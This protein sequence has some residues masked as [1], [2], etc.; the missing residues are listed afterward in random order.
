MF[1]AA[2][3]V[4]GPLAASRSAGNRAAHRL[5]PWRAKRCRGKPSRVLYLVVIYNE[6]NLPR[7]LLGAS[8][9][10]CP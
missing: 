6:S 9:P 4:L 10:V 3:F 5:H 2:R 1:C 8:T 7:R